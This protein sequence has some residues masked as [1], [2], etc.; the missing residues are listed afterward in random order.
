[1]TTMRTRAAASASSARAARRSRPSTRSSTSV[2]GAELVEE[3]LAAPDVGAA[4]ARRR[5]GSVGTV[6]SA[7]SLCQAR[8]AATTS[9]TSWRRPGAAAELGERSP[10]V[11]VDRRRGRARGRLPSPVSAK[12][13]TPVSW[14]T[15]ATWKRST[16]S[17]A[18]GRCGRPPAA[19][20]RRACPAPTQPAMNPATATDEERR[21]T[22]PKQ[23][24]GREAALHVR[25][26][27]QRDV[28]AQR[29]GVERLGPARRSRRT[30]PWTSSPCAARA[31]TTI[32]AS[33]PRRGARRRRGAPRRRR[34]CRAG[35][36][37]R[38]AGRRAWP[39]SCAPSSTPS[40][41]PPGLSTS[42]CG[43]SPPG[44]HQQR[45]GVA[46]GAQGQRRAVGLD[47][48]SARRW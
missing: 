46:R 48:R 5:L 22:A 32:L 47:G 8:A 42:G 16:A 27:D 4:S 40:G 17:D 34:P 29:A 1:M 30:T 12:P 35:R 26:E 45:R 9:W 2:R 28:V 24:A 33:P 39:S 7:C 10:G 13:R 23:L 19:G 36:P 20:C 6:G 31:A 43:T 25:I 15:S 37:S 18:P 11:R 3:P 14:S 44:G 41:G 21:S 38:A